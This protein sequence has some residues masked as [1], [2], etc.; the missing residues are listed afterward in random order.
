MIN[1]GLS[2][3][4]CPACLGGD[5]PLCREYRILG[6]HLPGTVAEEVVVPAINLAPV[7]EG[8]PWPQAAAFPMATLTAW[9]MLA[10]RAAL[11]GGETVLIWGV[12]GGVAMAALQIAVLLGARPIV[13]SGSD[14]KLEVARAHGAAVTLNHATTDVVAA[15]RQ[16]TGGRGADVVV[17]SVGARTWTDSLRALRR[18]GRV[19]VCGAT[20]GPEAGFD[21]RRLFWHQWSILGS[22]MG[23]R[24]E[25]AEV[26]RLAHQGRLWPVVDRVVPL[27]RGTEA[28]DRMR[29]GEQ[30]GKL[31]IEVA[32]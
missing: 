15:V 7:P 6:E 5:D 1:P 4:R 32:T 18:G 14:A 19:V 28:Y 24:R 9:R 21:L 27:A 16:E 8:M 20:T 31:V 12:G 22:T 17:D 3:G 23:S 26:V 13:T 10:S 2:C 25:F 30:T 11:R 29:R